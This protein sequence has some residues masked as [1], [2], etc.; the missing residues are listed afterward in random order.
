[1]TQITIRTRAGIAARI[2]GWVGR[3]QRDLSDRLHAAGDA[4]ALQHGWTVTAGTGWFGFGA[5]SYRDPR[6]NT[7]Q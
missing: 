2:S 4:A 5:R 7:R 1:M 6:F 3:R